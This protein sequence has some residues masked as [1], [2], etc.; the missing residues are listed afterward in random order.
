MPSSYI[1]VSLQKNG[2]MAAALAGADITNSEHTIDGTIS[3]ARS[4]GTYRVEQF[5]TAIAK[6]GDPCSIIKQRPIIK[7]YPTCDYAHRVIDAAIDL[8]TK[9]AAE[10]RDVYAL[11][12]SVPDYY[13]NLLVYDTP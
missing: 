6:P 5:A 7:A 10:T 2:V 9:L 1:L 4:M 3:L 13:L 12:I 8:R 11:D